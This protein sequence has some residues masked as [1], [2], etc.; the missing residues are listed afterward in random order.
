MRT[1]GEKRGGKVALITGASRGIGAAAARRMARDG[2]AI[3]VNYV[4]NSQAADGVVA[5]IAAA[6]GDAVAVQADVADRDQRERLFD[7][8]MAEYGRLDILVNNAG[9]DAFAS[10]AE[11]DQAHIDMLMTINVD[12]AIFA[13]QR[14]AQLMGPEGGRIINISSI[15]TRTPQPNR[16]IYGASKA[17]LEAITESFAAEL[18]PRRITVNAVRPGS[19][20]TDMTRE[21]IAGAVREAV[22]AKTPLGRLGQPEDI[23]GIIAF[24]ASDDAAWITGE[25]I[26]ADG[27]RLDM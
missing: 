14:A 2:V 26:A 18:G 19:T 20:E 11:I 3:A 9:A 4:A 16:A 13:C 6:G 22:E 27:G 15:I 24:L 7:A 5:D 23:A 12:A 10:L 8:V 1:S 21:R 17:A 25:I